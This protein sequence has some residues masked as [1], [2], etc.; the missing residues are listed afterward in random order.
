MP[1]TFS[2]PAIVLPFFKHQKYFSSTGLIVGSVVPDFEYFLRMRIKSTCSH[3][4][5]GIFLFDFPIAVVLCVIFHQFV[6]SKLYENS[7]LFFKGRLH[8]K[9]GIDWFLSLKKRWLIFSLSILVGI[10]SHLFW[11]SFT[12]TTGYFVERVSFL[13]KSYEILSFQMAGYKI[14]QHGSTVIGGFILLINFVHLPV[15]KVYASP[16]TRLYWGMVTGSTLVVL[17]I[18]S[19][20]ADHELAIGNAVVTVISGFLIG[21]LLTSL[22]FRWK[23][24]NN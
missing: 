15:R 8:E 20:K 4:L 19:V 22:L 14:L 18:R 1:F 2:H 13:K 7:P 5:E 23:K 17:V 11:D 24:S 10:C 3:S 9:M 16:F 6:K 12:H 21:L